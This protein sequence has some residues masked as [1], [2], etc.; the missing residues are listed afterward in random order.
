MKG[1]RAAAAAAAVAA[2]AAAAGSAAAAEEEWS[3]VGEGERG[4]GDIVGPFA[5]RPAPK[6]R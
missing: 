5:D 2:A 3:S 6:L 4:G 1:S